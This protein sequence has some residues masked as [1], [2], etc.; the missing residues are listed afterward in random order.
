M[1]RIELMSAI[2]NIRNG[3]FFKVN[4]KSSVPVKSEYKKEGIEAVKFVLCV[5]RTGVKYNNIA[6]VIEKKSREDYVPPK[7]KADNKVWIQADK[8]Y[9]NTNTNLDYFRLGCASAVKSK[10]VY[11]AFNKDGKEIPFDK[12]FAIN[13]YWNNNNEKPPVF[14]VKVDNIIS[15]G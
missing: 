15:I 10:V 4:Y 5:A 9:T 13:S 3:S 1:T 7:P 14:D 2:K 12:N 8:L 6:S 11:K